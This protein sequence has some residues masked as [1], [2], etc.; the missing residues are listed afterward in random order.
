MAAALPLLQTV[1]TAYR[2]LPLE[3]AAAVT[4]YSVEYLQYR[5]EMGT[6]LAGMMDNE[7]MVAVTQDNRLVEIAPAPAPEPEGDDINARLRQIRREDFAH[8]EGQPITVSEAETR[9]NVQRRTLIN[10]KTRGYIKVL[11][12]GYRMELNEADVAFCAAIY[13]VRRPYGSRAPLLDEDG[14]PYLI[15]YPDLA[16]RRRKVAQPQ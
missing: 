6:I 8:L 1:A 14:N 3:E 10:W 5:T 2:F 7:L 12:D 13:H 4:G 11:K 9:Y 15:K 16:H